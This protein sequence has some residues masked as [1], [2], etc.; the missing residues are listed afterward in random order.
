V[1]KEDEEGFECVVPRA[2]PAGDQLGI[3]VRQD[4]ERTRQ[5]EEGHGHRAR[6][7]FYR[8][9]ELMDLARGEGQARLRAEPDC[10]VPRGT[11]AADLDTPGPEP[12]EEPD[13]LKEVEPL[14]IL[15]KLAL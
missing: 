7:T 13:G 8:R 6:T 4:A 10:L 12:L 14:R 3:A 1:L 11:V 2:D 15:V 5:A 9:V